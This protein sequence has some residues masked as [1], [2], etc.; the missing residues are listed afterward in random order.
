MELRNIPLQYRMRSQQSMKKN[1]NVKIAQN[2][3]CE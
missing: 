1:L 2:H 3:A